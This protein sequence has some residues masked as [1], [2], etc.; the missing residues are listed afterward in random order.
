M[1]F[2]SLCELERNY[3]NFTEDKYLSPRLRFKHRALNIYES[4]GQ[5]CTS[6]YFY[7]FL[8][9]WFICSFHIDGGVEFL[10]EQE[11]KSRLTNNVN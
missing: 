7:I 2:K 9:D 5:S 4:A 3:I 10:N 6:N 11:L 1:N 8:S